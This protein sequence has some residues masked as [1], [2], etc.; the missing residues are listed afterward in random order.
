MVD[1]ATSKRPGIIPEKRIED[2][3]G[4]QS[5][6]SP[7]TFQTSS[8]LLRQIWGWESQVTYFCQVHVPVSLLSKSVP[9]PQTS[10]SPVHGDEDVHKDVN[11]GC[12][13]G[14]HSNMLQGLTVKEEQ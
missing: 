2:N 13:M 11:S 1:V 3:L 6:Q 4:T 12:E 14:Y 5:R 9:P 8:F 7:D 10:G